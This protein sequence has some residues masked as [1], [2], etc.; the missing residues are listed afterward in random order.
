MINSRISLSIRGA[1]LRVAFLAVAFL[2][3]FLLVLGGADFFV[4]D[5]FAPAFVIEAFDLFVV[6]LFFAGDF[7]ATMNLAFHLF[8]MRWRITA[9]R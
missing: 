4:A 2:A 1:L 5:L 6:V 9:V 3:V 7:R 8:A